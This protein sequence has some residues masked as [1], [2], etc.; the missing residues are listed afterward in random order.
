MKVNKGFT[1][2]ELLVAISILAILTVL[3]IPTLRS[4]QANN[5]DTKYKNYSKSV[6]TGAKLYNDSYNDDIFGAA[7]YGCETV[8]LTELMNKKVAKDIA[9]KNVTCNVSYKDSF[10]VVRKFNN[11]YAYNS[12]LYCV[13]DQNSVMYD[14]TDSTFDLCANATGIPE[15]NASLEKNTAN[16]SKKKSVVITISDEYGFVADQSFEYVWTTEKDLSKVDFSKAKVYNYNNKVIKT[17]GK[18]V[19]LNSKS[20]V[21]NSNV[22]G[23]IYLAIKPKRIQ[24]IINNSYTTTRLFGPFSYDHTAPKCPTVDNGGIVVKNQDGA[25]VAP[26]HSAKELYYTFSFKDSDF[27]NYDVYKS[28][29]GKIADAKLDS[30]KVTTLTYNPKIDGKYAL[31]FIIRD[32]AGNEKE[33]IIPTYIRDNI[34]PTCPTVAAKANG[35]TLKVNEWTTFDVNFT[36]GFSSDTVKWDWYTDNSASD[37]EYKNIKYKKWNTNPYS[38]STKTQGISGQGHRSILT[39]VYDEAGNGAKCPS[40]EYLIEKCAAT[41]ASEGAWSKCSVNCG[42]GT[43]TR[44]VTT[45]ST[46]TGHTSYVCSSKNESQDCNKQACPAF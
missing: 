8:S 36:F 21:Y 16:T 6:S 31:K 3:A 27:A 1:L 24:N 30:E 14:D 33:C 28:T 22:T 23:D 18:K 26:G 10:A 46:L 41:K 44:T 43:Q 17:S 12:Y 5:S 32:Y 40:G 34:P 37:L 15:L 39:Y 29:N 45:Y 42:G 19:Q 11:E 9:L 38:P 4:F 13:D 20:L 2:V 25:I 7:P 35:K